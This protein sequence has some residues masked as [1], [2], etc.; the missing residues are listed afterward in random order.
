MSATS[1][2]TDD[3]EYKMYFLINIEAGMG[4]GKAA[5][6]VGHAAMYITIKM[7]SDNSYKTIWNKYLKTGS[8]KVT[9]KSDLETMNKLLKQY[10]DQCIPIYDAGRT[11]LAPNTFT[12]LGFIPMNSQLKE[13][14]QCKLY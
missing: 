6:Q 8:T 3:S 10:P 1:T 5:A 7:M 14:T 12:V 9:L 13:L 11:Q 2:S 4:K